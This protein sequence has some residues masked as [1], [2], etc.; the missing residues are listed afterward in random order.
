MN[1]AEAAAA[2]LNKTGRG[3]RPLP[4]RG[5]IKSRIASKAYRAIL[6][7]FSPASSPQKKIMFKECKDVQEIMI[8]T[9]CMVTPSK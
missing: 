5:Q 2:A 1:D 9:N 8:C 7:W 6:L 3:R 4:K